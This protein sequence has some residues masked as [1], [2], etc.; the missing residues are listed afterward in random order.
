MN[1]AK[2]ST[3]EAELDQLKQVQFLILQ[4]HAVYLTVVLV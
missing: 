1:E 4:L 2:I 3:L